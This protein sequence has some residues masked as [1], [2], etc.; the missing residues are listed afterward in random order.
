MI[1][2]HCVVD[3]SALRGS[4]V[5]GEH[6]LAFWIET[7]DGSLLFDTGQSGD[8]LLHNA[9]MKGIEF[10]SCDAVAL[11]G[12]H[13]D[14]TGGIERF[15]NLSRPGIPLYASPDLFRERFSIKNGQTRH[16]GLRLSQAEIARHMDLR[17]S[18][19]PQEILP[20]IWTSGEIGERHDF[21]G[22]SA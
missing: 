12:A 17:L 16:I 20:G 3:N 8:V 10:S 14:H 4:A 6:G 15:V 13:Y 22:R 9:K 1:T 19:G 18:A 7:P 2:L 11:S 21:E 5:W